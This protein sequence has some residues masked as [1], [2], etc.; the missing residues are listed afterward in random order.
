MSLKMTSNVEHT[1]AYT[2]LEGKILLFQDLA[3]VV[4]ITLP[5]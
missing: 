3:V 4:L 1:K 5:I 2:F